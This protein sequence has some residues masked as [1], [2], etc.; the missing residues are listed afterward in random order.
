[1]SERFPDH[2]KRDEEIIRL[3]I[4]QLQKDT[5]ADFS[6]S[7]S[8]N[9]H[10]AFDE[11]TATLSV[12]LEEIHRLG[13]TALMQVLYRVDLPEKE[14]PPYSADFY[15]QLARKVIQREFRKVLIR[16]FH[17]EKG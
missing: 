5:G 4:A 14:V 7:L 12:R 10:T 3:T 8:G 13:R 1:M 17:S 11:L 15:P 16:K 2:Y 6:Q 9:P